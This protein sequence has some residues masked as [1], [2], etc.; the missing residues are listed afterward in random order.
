[1]RLIHLLIGVLGA[2][3]SANGWALGLGPIQQRSSL[4]EPFVGRIDVVDAQDVDFDSLKIG[5]APLERFERA[6]IPVSRAVLDLR[7]RIRRGAGGSA[8][9]EVSSQD[10]MR[11][12]VLNF[13]VEAVWERG[14]IFREYTVLLDPPAYAMSERARAAAT[15][16]GIPSSAQVS[17]YGPVAAGETL[18]GIA[19]R[20]TPAGVT[21]NQMMIA[22][23][24]ANPDAFIDGNINALKKGVVLAVPGAGE[25]RGISESDALAQVRSQSELWQSYR[26]SVAA[27]TPRAASTGPA[28]GSA[29]RREAPSTDAD[30]RLRLVAPDGDATSASGDASLMR[31]ELDART[32]EARDL[33]AKLVEA[34]EV[35]DLL[36]RQI[37]LKDDQLAALE[38]RLAGGG[39]TPV[40]AAAG[41]IAEPAPTVSEPDV[42]DVAETTDDEAV[43]DDE[44]ADL[45][46]LPEPEPE[47]ATPDDPAPPMAE[48][49]APVDDEGPAVAE[50]E[51]EPMPEPPA[52]EPEKDVRIDVAKPKAP[53]VAPPAPAAGGPLAGLIPPHIAE[54]VPGGVKTILGVVAAVVLGLVALVVKKLRGRGADTDVVATAT[55]SAPKR[56]DDKLD[57]TIEQAMDEGD[58]IDPTL[59]TL[60][61]LDAEATL[62]GTRDSLTGETP[63]IDLESTIATTTDQ[64]LVDVEPESDPLEEVNVYLAY[65]RFDQAEELVRDAIERYPNEHQYKLRLLE[66]FYSANDKV[67]Y[68]IAARDL[69]DAVGEQHPL[70]ESALAMWQEM[71]PNRALFE[72][73]DG[74]GDTMAATGAAAS[75]FVD[76][77]GAGAEDDAAGGDTMNI[78]PGAPEALERTQVGEADDAGTGGDAVFD[79]TAG[80]DDDF[81]DDADVFDLTATT[82]VPADD[83]ILDLTATTD[84]PVA[85]DMIDLTSTGDLQEAMKDGVHEGEEDVFD[86]S[87]ESSPAEASAETDV[88]DITSSDEDVFDLGDSS[89]LGELSPETPAAPATPAFDSDETVNEAAARGSAAVDDDQVIEFDLSDT[90]SP[91]LAKTQV[92]DPDDEDEVLELTGGFSVSDLEGTDG[93]VEAPRTTPDDEDPLDLSLAPTEDIDEPSTDEASLDFDFS[94]TETSDLED[95]EIEDTLELPRESVET[96]SSLESGDES[97]ADLA[98][99]MELSMSDLGREVDDEEGGS[100]SDGLDLSLD[101]DDGEMPDFTDTEPAGEAVSFD[102][103]EELSLDD[104]DDY[105]TKLNLAKAYVELGDHDGARTI[106]SEVRQSGSPEQKAQ[107]EELLG[108]LG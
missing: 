82:D 53:S 95:L 50:A 92:V 102:E 7:F 107:A 56:V 38:A 6:G 30:S 19:Q 55:E 68:E 52:P 34:N 73:G 75:T 9:V 93:D 74:M 43:E 26:G 61:D 108:E 18:Y 45:L 76:L 1:M 58:D 65:E 8:Y 79:I 91:P 62:E 2:S 16:A 57:S 59:D 44:F 46:A 37:E 105:D 12:P 33:S 88:F 96:L 51:P 5:L 3:V 47:V 85:D 24:N 94:L 69:V 36:K 22:L 66:V 25:A 84:A 35:I 4:N 72:E 83:E 71:S 97:L 21:V 10:P 81:G 67:K 11:E 63:A 100:V 90:V 103:N 31:E 77:S 101:F 87:G 86:I 70:W 49:D 60:T 89:V 40:P 54:A 99:S 14:Q 32:Q 41:E 23:L 48:D 106:L 39:E 80:D 104:A 20:V 15:P 17:R 78:S 64:T 27:A 13:L 29:S 98:A 42:P 28:S